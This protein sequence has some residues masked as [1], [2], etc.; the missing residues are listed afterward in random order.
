M[1]VLVGVNTRILRCGPA[2]SI[3]TSGNLRGV[4]TAA[5]LNEEGDGVLGLG[6][7]S[8][9]SSGTLRCSCCD[10]HRLVF[11]D[12]A[13]ADINV[14]RVQV[15]RNI[16]IT[17]SPGLEGL[18]L[19]LRLAHVTI[20]VVEVTEGLGLS[21]RIRVCRVKALVVLDED[22]DAV[23]ARGLDQSEVVSQTLCCW[24]GDENVDTALNCVQ[25]NGIVGR[26]GGEDSDGGSLG[27]GI[28]SSLVCI[29]VGLVVR[30]E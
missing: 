30:G 18:E 21:T 2:S 5:P 6:D 27:E 28:N 7:T 11:W 8:K 17:T 14:V 23:L 1:E 26:I 22:E 29:R 9:R 25:R 4:I 3:D 15:V 24:L 20:E 10:P 16:G 12:H 19:A 13:L